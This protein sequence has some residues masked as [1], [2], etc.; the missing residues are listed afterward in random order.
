ML[1][2]KPYQTP[3]WPPGNRDREAMCCSFCGGRDHGYE[4]CPQRPPS[5]NPAEPNF[6]DPRGDD[7]I[8]SGPGEGRQGA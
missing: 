8:K 1:G 4:D 2:R 5:D 3:R 7:L 6:D